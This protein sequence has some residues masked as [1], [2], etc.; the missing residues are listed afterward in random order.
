MDDSQAGAP[1]ALTALDHNTPEGRRVL[2]R[3]ATLLNGGIRG[4]TDAVTPVA[5]AL[6][7]FLLRLRPAPRFLFLGPTGVGKTELCRAFTRELFGLEHLH[8]FDCSEFGSP[9]SS[10]EVLLGDRHGD[11]GRLGALA[12]HS[13]GTLLFD[14]AEKGSDRFLRLLLQ[15]LEPGRVTLASGREINLRP[16]I[17]VCT[18]NIGSAEILEA[19]ASKFRTL[20]R[21]IVEQAQ[22]TLRPEVF[23]RFDEVIVFRPLEL[24]TQREIVELKLKEYLASI[25]YSPIAYLTEVIDFL[26]RF[27]FDRRYGARPL[28]RAIRRHVGEAIARDLMAEGA[29]TGT[30]KVEQG[31]QKLVLAR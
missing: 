19:L 20:E 17:I 26:L 9:Q 7:C 23:N 21:H 11:P 15:I 8:C 31:H 30:L 27:G 6:I 24:D 16:F 12:E 14:E 13:G 2:S 10:L 29:G 3:L 5:L 1:L 25:P 4:Q 22:E 28:V 18:G